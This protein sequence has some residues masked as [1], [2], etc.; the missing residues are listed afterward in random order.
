M[1]SIWRRAFDR[2]ERPVSTAAES[3]VQSDTFMDLAALTF[4]VRRHVGG[5]IEQAAD[6]WLHAFGLVSRRDVARL[7]NQ[8]AS[9]ER[10]VRDLA[11]E[12]RPSGARPG[13]DAPQQRTEPDRQQPPRT[14]TR[15][16]A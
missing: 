14:R 12:A 10:Q 2:I 3:W 13:S 6:R 16:A 15:E 7:M 4:K 8:I 11:G 5:E 1:S 9:L